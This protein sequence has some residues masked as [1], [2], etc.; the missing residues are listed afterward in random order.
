[1]SG[2]Q[3]VGTEVVLLPYPADGGAV[4]WDGWAGAFVNDYCVQCHSPTASCF[5]SGCHTPGDPR[6]PDFQEKSTGVADAPLIR[7]GISVVQE[8]SWNCGS[9]APETFPVSDGT[10]PMPTNEQRALLAGWIDAGCP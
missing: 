5:G 3:G 1:M 8:T 10:N 2:S 9:T 6:T 7:C 4:E